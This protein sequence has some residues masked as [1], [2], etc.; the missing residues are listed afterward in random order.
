MIKKL[1]KM[2]SNEDEQVQILEQSIMSNW[3][4]IF[5]L[6]EEQKKTIEKTNRFVGNN[7]FNDVNFDK[8]YSNL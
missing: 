5:P 3:Q 2:S 4:G 6:K 8:F 7:S 1:Q